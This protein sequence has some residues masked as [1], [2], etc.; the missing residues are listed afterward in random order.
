[1][2][3]LRSSVLLAALVLLPAV[4]GCG[5]AAAPGTSASVGAVT[6]PAPASQPPGDGASV[7]ANNPPIADGTFTSGKW[8]V[9]ISGDVN[10]TID[11]PLQGGFSMTTGGTTLLSYTDP[12]T[13]G[14][15]GIVLS[16][17]G[18]GVTLSTPEVSAAGGDAGDAN[19]CTVTLT[20]S[21]ASSVAGTFDCK[22]LLGVVASTAKQ[23]TIDMRGTFEASR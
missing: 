6:T 15:G 18:N 22:R 11:A 16:P 13:G 23:V 2:S 20:K 21:D 19:V 4:A 1:M 3:V 9:E 10:A 17:D 5:G 12:A 7:P 8:H 14:G